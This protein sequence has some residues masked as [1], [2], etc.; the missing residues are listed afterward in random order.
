MNWA[1]ARDDR[2]DAPAEEVTHVARNVARAMENAVRDAASRVPG[3]AG[4]A[5]DV[6][7][8][9]SRAIQKASDQ[10]LSTGAILSGGLALGLLVGGANRILVLLALVP[11]LAMGLALLDRRA[12][13]AQGE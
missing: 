9:A 10:N 4:A 5:R 7:T 12:S 2:D 6:L 11:A 13:T 1:N 8:D 3:S